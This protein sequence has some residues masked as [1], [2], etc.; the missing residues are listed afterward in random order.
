MEGVFIR[1]LLTRGA[2]GV[3]SIALLASCSLQ[4]PRQI[5]DPES[6]RFS[7][8]LTG[9][10]R[11]QERIVI[12]AHGM[13]HHDESWVIARTALLQSIG[14]QVTRLDPDVIPHAGR[15]V[16][17][18][19]HRIAFGNDVLHVKFVVWSDLTLAAKSK[20]CF[21]IGKDVEAASMCSA[22]GTTASF[23]LPRAPLNELLKSRIM[24]TCL[25]DAV[26]YAGQAK[27]TIR[28]GFAKAV[29]RSIARN[30]PEKAN[31]NAKPYE[32]PSGTEPIVLV[33]ESLGSKI[34][35]DAVD[36]ATA[37][38]SRNAVLRMLV[39]DRVNRRGHVYTLAN[40]IPILELSEDDIAFRAPTEA[41]AKIQS[42]PPTSLERALIQLRADPSTRASL[43]DS[44]IILVAF[45]DPNDML[46]YRIPPDYFT[47]A[48]IEVV[49]AMSSNSKTILR[50]FERPDEAHFGYRSNN[51]VIK[52]LLCGS[53][54]PQGCPVK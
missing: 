33:S 15:H 32:W 52:A 50:L 2:I 7:G 17:V 34:L 41:S 14:A 9:T 1:N 48:Q 46:S 40:Q 8:L 51:N 19:P 36:K 16:R 6:A 4:Y 30:E 42:A 25:A 49:N 12:W 29:C 47:D 44:R 54:P 5:L 13:C 37:A 43:D 45:S 26:I 11:L 21:D 28:D 22:A 3:T 27:E 24:D 39:Q 35:F 18:W 20:L 53:H 10:P 23:P 31:C 38:G